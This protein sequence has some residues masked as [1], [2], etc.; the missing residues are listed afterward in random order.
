[1]SAPTFTSQTVTDA[2]AMT[3]VE[4]EVF[5]RAFTATTQP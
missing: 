5:D 3:E 1:M 4:A 2:I